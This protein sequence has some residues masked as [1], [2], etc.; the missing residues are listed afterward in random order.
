VQF[1]HND[2]NLPELAKTAKF[3]EKNGRLVR[4]LVLMLQEDNGKFLKLH[5]KIF[6]LP[7]SVPAH[8]ALISSKESPSKYSLE[9]VGGVN[10]IL[11]D[12]LQ[13]VVA[14]SFALYNQG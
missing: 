10:E 6:A 1:L 8:V 11:D 3:V 2:A 12:N 13:K 4:D 7:E 5:T 9:L 14:E